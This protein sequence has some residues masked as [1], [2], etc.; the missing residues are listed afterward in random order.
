MLSINPPK[1][2]VKSIAV[3]GM[4]LFMVYLPAAA[5]DGGGDNTPLPD[6]NENMT[7]MDWFIGEWD[8]ESRMLIDP[9]NDQWLEES[10]TAVHTS[11][12][13][14]HIILEHFIGPLGGEPFEAWSIRKYNS[15]TERWQ[16]RWMDT[17]TPF[18]INWGGTYDEETNEYIGYGEFFLDENF[19]IAGD[20]AVREIFYDITEDSFLWRY[21]TTEDGGETWAVTW[22]LAYTRQQN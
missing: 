15:N 10:L 17:S 18:I 22:T 13:N 5:Q 19:E 11:E 21:E 6:P 3:I 8:I 12:L 2:I 4:I 7:Q 16:Q 20:R 14:G 1:R 9:A